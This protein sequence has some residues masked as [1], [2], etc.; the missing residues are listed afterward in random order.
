VLAEWEHVVDAWQ[1][2]SWEAY[3]D[4]PRLGRKTRLPEKARMV[5]WSISDKVQEDLRSRGL[6]TEV[7]LFAQLAERVAQSKHPAFEYAVI[8]ESQD[9]SVSELRFLA[10][11]GSNRPNALFFTGDIGQRIFQ[12]PR[13]HGAVGGTYRTCQTKAPNTTTTRT[14][15]KAYPSTEMRRPSCVG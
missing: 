11:L 13:Q 15:A 8:D 12:P 3:R 6:L 2:T 10:A 14:T 1:V 5:L 7:G 9:V 4:V